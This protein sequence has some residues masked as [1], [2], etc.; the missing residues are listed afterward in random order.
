MCWRGVQ[1][2]VLLRHTH[3]LPSPISLCKTVSL[4]HWTSDSPSRFQLV[5]Q[6]WKLSKAWPVSVS[7]LC[8]KS[9]TETEGKCSFAKFF[10][11]ML[12]CSRSRVLTA[13]FK[14][15]PTFMKLKTPVVFLC[16]FAGH[17]AFWSVCAETPIPSTDLRNPRL[18]LGLLLLLQSNIQLWIQLLLLL[19]SNIASEQWW[20]MPPIHCCFRAGASAAS[21][22]SSGVLASCCP[23]QLNN[24][25]VDRVNLTTVVNTSLAE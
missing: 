20:G 14:N 10:L 3:T 25:L 17:A 8:K 12:C 15:L 5:L 16:L 19:Q 7:W 21:V 23:L 1:P 6:T 13:H 11:T 4:S 22:G 24:H 18:R 2:P 9:G